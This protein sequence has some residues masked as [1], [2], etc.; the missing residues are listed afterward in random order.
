[1]FSKIDL[2]SLIKVSV[3]PALNSYL[4]LVKAMF[5]LKLIVVSFRS[6]VEDPPYFLEL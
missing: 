5:L 1:M 3:F 6:F 2:I 4:P